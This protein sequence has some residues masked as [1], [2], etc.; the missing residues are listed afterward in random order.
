MLDNLLLDLRYGARTLMRRAPTFS[1][2]AVVTIALGV[3]L[4]TGI[5]T[6]VNGVLFRDLPVP[7]G[8]ELVAIYQTVEGVPDRQPDGIGLFSTAE[9]ETYRDRTRSLSGLVGS[10]DPTRTTLGGDVPRQVVGFLVTCNW[11]DV[12][13]QPPALGRAFTERDCAAGA[14]PVAVLD[15]DFWV[16]QLGADPDIVGRTVELNRQL[17][18]VVGV[19]AEGA[20]GGTVYRAAYFAPI[21]AQPLLLPRETGFDDDGVGWLLLMGRRASGVSVAQARAELQTIAATIDS[22]TPG[23]STALSVARA[24]PPSFNP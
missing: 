8:H 9:Y 16:T 15:H 17:V 7:R 13:E 12:L 24:T 4:N 11:F 5:F 22:E 10:S 14:G 19:G 2:V 21:S 20:Y 23:R 3:G 6:I 1:A 18:T